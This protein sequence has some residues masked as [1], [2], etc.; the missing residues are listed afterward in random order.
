MLLKIKIYIN[1]TKLIRKNKTLFVYLNGNIMLNIL[2]LL[3]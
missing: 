2:S 1:I 3:Y